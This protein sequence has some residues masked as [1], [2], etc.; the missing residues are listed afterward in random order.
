MIWRFCLFSLIGVLL[1]A[2]EIPRSKVNLRSQDKEAA[3]GAQ[4]ANEVRNRTSSLGDAAVLGFVEDVGW[5]LAPHVTGANSHWEFAVIRDDAGGNTHEPLSMPGGYIFVPANL[6][7]EANNEAELAGMLA[8]AMAHVAAIHQSFGEE[9]RLAGTP[10]IFLGGWMGEGAPTAMPLGFLQIQRK[11]ELDA[12]RAAVNVMAAAGYNPAAFVDYI[13]RAQ[14]ALSGDAGKYSPLPLRDKRISA[15]ETAAA[16]LAP[17][18]RTNSDIFIA[19]QER[20]R[21]LV[22]SSA[23]D[24]PSEEPPALRRKNE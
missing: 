23:G 24:V 22:T 9:A 5:R 15:L 19:I 7:L 11:K 12:D 6:I 13:R 2:Q 10:L 3:L 8:H 14:P 18:S 17:G 21:E 4:L 20:V 16:T 1:N